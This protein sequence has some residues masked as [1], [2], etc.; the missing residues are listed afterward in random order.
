MQDLLEG[1]NDKQYEAVINTDGPCLVIA[2]AGS[3]KTKVLTHKI[4]YLMQEKDIKPWNI[5]AIT[6]TNKASNEMKERV[7]ALVGDDAKDMWI[8][9]FYMC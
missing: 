8:G 9:T 7:E 1:L 2:G 4:A 3:G 6:F 5:L